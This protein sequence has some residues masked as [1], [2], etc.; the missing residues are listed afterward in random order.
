MKGLG[1]VEDSGLSPKSSGKLLKGFQGMC[2]RALG[3]I[4][5]EKIVLTSG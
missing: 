4:C 2:R 3:Q 1:L 5:F